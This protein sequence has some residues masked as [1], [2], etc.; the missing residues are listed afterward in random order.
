VSVSLQVAAV[1]GVGPGIGGAVARKWAQQ[2][3][4]VAC[5]ARTAEKAETLAKELGNG[6]AGYACDVSDAAQLAQVVGRIEAELGEIDA[7]IYNA[8]SGVFKGYEEITHDEFR[9]SWE[10][11]TFGL[12]AAAQLVCP[13]MAARGRGVVAV[14]GATASLRGR[15]ATAGFAAAKAAQ[16]SLAQTL[17]RDLGPKVSRRGESERTREQGRGV[18]GV[19]GFSARPAWMSESYPGPILVISASDPSH[20]GVII[21]GPWARAERRRQGTGTGGRGT[22]DGGDGGRRPR[23]DR[24]RAARGVGAGRSRSTPRRGG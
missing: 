22:R 5:V 13:K 4:A 17:A 19:R 12:L 1:L 11:N 23:A 16:R 10:V 20:F 14:T 15:P 8:G 9:R 21:T 2:G 3:Y 7:L 24:G 6:S 18:C